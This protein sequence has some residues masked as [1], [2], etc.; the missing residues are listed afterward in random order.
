MPWLRHF[1]ITDV[2][3]VRWPS[4]LKEL[5]KTE[6]RVLNVQ[7]EC[8]KSRRRHPVT[9]IVSEELYWIPE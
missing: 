2:A 1:S 7:E 9:L 6:Q 5:M 3:V 8:R 4:T